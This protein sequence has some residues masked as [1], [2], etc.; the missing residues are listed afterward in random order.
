MTGELHEVSFQLGALN[1]QIAALSQRLDGIHASY[2]DKAV[3]DADFH[4][5][6]L[7]NLDAVQRLVN[8]VNALTVRLDR[9]EPEI[10]LIRR[11]RWAG[12]G[13]VA[14]IGMAAGATGAAVKT[15]VTRLLGV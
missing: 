8:E 13:I 14:G 7:E 12:M 11:A 15:A 2:R 9:I 3:E 10:D 1:S 4:S 6:M 5:H